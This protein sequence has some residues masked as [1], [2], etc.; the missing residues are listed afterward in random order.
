MVLRIVQEILIRGE[1][2]FRKL[3]E[4]YTKRTAK[5]VLLCK[6]L[7]WRKLTLKEWLMLPHIFY[8]RDLITRFSVETLS[9]QILLQH[10]TVPFC[11]TRLF[12]S[13]CSKFSRCYLCMQKL[14]VHNTTKVIIILLRTRHQSWNIFEILLKFLKYQEKNKKIRINCLVFVLSWHNVVQYLLWQHKYFYADR[15]HVQVL[16]HT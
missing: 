7:F 2:L 5:S 6:E 16:F 12:F 13:F 3:A 11:L 9:P 14:L 8:G 10:S 15:L 4:D 1:F